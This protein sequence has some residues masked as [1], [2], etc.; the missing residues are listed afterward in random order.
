MSYI[1]E[2]ETVKIFS[3]PLLFNKII[4]ITATLLIAKLVV[5]GLLWRAN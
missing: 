3:P 4:I 1:L 5:Q 2:W